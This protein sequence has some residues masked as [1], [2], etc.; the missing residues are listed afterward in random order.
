MKPVPTVGATPQYGNAT[1]R[2]NVETSV[3][4]K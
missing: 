2:D 3:S 1:V 4:W